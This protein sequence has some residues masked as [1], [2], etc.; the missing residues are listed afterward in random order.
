M[1]QQHEVSSSVA[2]TEMAPPAHEKSAKPQQQQPPPPKAPPPPMLDLP[3]GW[4]MVQAEGEAEPFYYNASTGVSQWEKP[5]WPSASQTA[6]HIPPPPPPNEPP[7]L[8]A[9]WEERMDP[10]TGRS[11]YYNVHTGASSWVWPDHV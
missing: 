9:G 5:S 1:L 2:L 10:T 6:S 8:P 4:E 11:Y 3:D 7:A